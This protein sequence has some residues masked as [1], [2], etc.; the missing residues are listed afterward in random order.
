MRKMVIK[1]TPTGQDKSDESK[2][3]VAGP[4]DEARENDV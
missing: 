3:R 4:E 1:I 2:K